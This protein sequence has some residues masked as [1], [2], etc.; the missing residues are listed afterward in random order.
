MQILIWVDRREEKPLSE[1]G[2][3]SEDEEETRSAGKEV[4]E[5]GERNEWRRVGREQR[6][7]STELAQLFLEEGTHWH[8]EEQQYDTQGQCQAGTEAIKHRHS[9]QHHLVLTHIYTYTILL[10]YILNIY[11]YIYE[12]V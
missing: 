3:E 10:I 5:D 2:R 1:N 12:L 8:Q 9:H 11:K 4:E 6:P 7:T